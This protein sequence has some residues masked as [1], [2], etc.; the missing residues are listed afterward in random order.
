MRVFALSVLIL[1]ADAAAAP[2]APHYVKLKVGAS[3]ESEA[4]FHARILKAACDDPSIAKVELTADRM[5]MHFT[6]L[7]AGST[8]CHYS[9]PASLHIRNGNPFFVTVEDEASEVH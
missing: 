5:R 7:R 1:A 4:H 8:T 6:G 2:P 9:H 3:V